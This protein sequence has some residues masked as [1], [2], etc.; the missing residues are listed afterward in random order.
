MRLIYNFV[1]EVA[2]AGGNVHSDAIQKTGGVRRSALDA[3]LH[4]PPKVEHY[5]RVYMPSDI[6]NYDFALLVSGWSAQHADI[7]DNDIV[8]CENIK[9]GFAPEAGYI[10]ITKAEHVN[11]ANGI[12]P[13]WKCLRVVEEVL[14]DGTISVSTTVRLADESKLEFENIPISAVIGHGVYSFPVSQIE[15]KMH[16]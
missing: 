1:A 4:E 5:R 9:S 6:P 7:A 3:T 11:S 16:Q 2:L 14:D 13:D 8:L 12:H 10:V 15:P